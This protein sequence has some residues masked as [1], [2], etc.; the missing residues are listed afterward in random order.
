MRLDGIHHITAITGDAQQALDFYSG[1]LGLRFV[2]KTVNFDDPTAYHLYFGDERG[3]PGSILTFFEYPG[4]PAGRPGTGMVH[5]LVW[6]GADREALDFWQERLT[7][8]GVSARRGGSW[9]RFADPEGLELELVVPDGGDAPPRAA[10]TIGRGEAP[11]AA[12]AKIPGRQRL[13]GFAGVRAYTASPEGSAGLL[14]DVL[15]FEH[16]DGMWTL[17]GGRRVA[18]YAYDAPPL[19]RGLPG[20]GTVHHIAWAVRD[21]EQ[22]AWRRRLVVAGA[23]AT[24]IIDRT[25]FRSVYFRE[26]SGVLFELAT[27]GP[28]FTVDEPL[29]TL[30]ETLK[31]PAR[32]EPL[33]ARLEATLTP[34]Q[35]RRAA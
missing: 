19:Q 6:R 8:A 14:G 11:R 34:L 33:R 2:K 22:A 15:G 3:S 12:V 10:A 27:L 7:R 23:A 35:T 28:G 5:R 16:D 4:V 25:Y 21:D 17:A 1:L 26:P 29:E 13:L 24:E 9:L 30:G 31:L 18:R 20:A 32:Y